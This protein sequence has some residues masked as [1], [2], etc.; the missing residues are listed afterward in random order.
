MTSYGS[1]FQVQ[2]SSF[3]DKWSIW[4]WKTETK[5]DASFSLLSPLQSLISCPPKLS[6]GLLRW[7]VYCDLWEYILIVTVLPL[8]HSEMLI[9]FFRLS[10][11]WL[12][13][14]L[15]TTFHWRTG[16]R[17]WKERQEASQRSPFIDVCVK[18]LFRRAAR[19]NVNQRFCVVFQRTVQL[20]RYSGIF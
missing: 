18:A 17:K 12:W 7:E 16:G 4:T 19:P 14:I 13:C 1:I 15:K 10:F 9:S 11:D 5:T 8:S 20:S 6:E 3:T 2:A